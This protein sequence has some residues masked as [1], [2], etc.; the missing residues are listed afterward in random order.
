MVHSITFILK[1]LIFNIKNNPFLYFPNLTVVGATL[2]TI[3][4]SGSL[5]VVFNATLFNELVVLESLL[6]QQCK[7]LTTIPNVPGHVKTLTYRSCENTDVQELQLD[8]FCTTVPQQSIIVSESV[9]HSYLTNLSSRPGNTGF[10][11][12]FCSFMVQRSLSCLSC[13]VCWIH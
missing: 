12:D 3:Y 4:L 6:F 11:G 5:L 7:Q 8:H 9:L 1:H 10:Y 2:K 13:L